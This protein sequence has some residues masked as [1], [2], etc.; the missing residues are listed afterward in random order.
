M[1]CEGRD[2]VF[3]DGSEE[4]VG[5]VREHSGRGRDRQKALL[6]SECLCVAFL[7]HTGILDSA[8]AL[9]LS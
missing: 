4:Q 1:D 7:L 9:G 8:P 3:W 2:E 6:D 5:R